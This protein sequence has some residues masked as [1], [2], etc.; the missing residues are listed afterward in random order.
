MMAELARVMYVGIKRMEED[1]H[2]FLKWLLPLPL[3]CYVM[4]THNF[5]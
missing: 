2:A 3:T 4:L 5:F 1:W